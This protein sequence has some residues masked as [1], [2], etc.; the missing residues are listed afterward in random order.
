MRTG[1]RY[2]FSINKC[3]SFDDAAGVSEFEVSP[4]I[5]SEGEAKRPAPSPVRR[6]AKPRPTGR[7]A[8][9]SKPSSGSESDPVS[10]PGSLEN[11]Q[12]LRPGFRLEKPKP[13]EQPKPEP[14]KEPEPKPEV[15][16]SESSNQK[17]SKSLGLTSLVRMMKPGL[18]EIIEDDDEAP[19]TRSVFRKADQAVSDTGGSTSKWAVF[20][21]YT[22]REM[23]S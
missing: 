16:E 10:P 12:E 7:P 8:P 17:S 19:K 3:L 1:K 21:K 11:S 18:Q 5:V 6:G 22:F 15:K 4:A 14:Q 13:A 23:V 2:V 20:K 9:A